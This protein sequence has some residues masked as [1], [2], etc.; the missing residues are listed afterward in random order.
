MEEIVPISKFKATCLSLLDKVNK[1]GQRVQEAKKGSRL[2]GGPS[3]Q[4]EK[5]GLG[6]GILP[7]YRANK[8]G[9]RRPRGVRNGWEA[10]RK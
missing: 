6:V 1:T 4:T 2:P 3:S 5:A 8:R 7:V 9:Y 10:L